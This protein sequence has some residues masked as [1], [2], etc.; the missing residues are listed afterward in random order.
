M[1]FFMVPPAY[2]SPGINPKGYGSDPNPNRSEKVGW[3]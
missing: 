3:S 1:T 2:L